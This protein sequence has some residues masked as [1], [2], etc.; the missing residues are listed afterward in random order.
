MNK[1]HFV[2]LALLITS[3]LCPAQSVHLHS[4]FALVLPKDSLLAQ[5]MVT[6]L[7]SFLILAHRG[8]VNNKFI[9]KDQMAETLVQQ[10]EVIDI[11]KNTKNKIDFFYQPYL[12]N[13]I[14]LESDKYLIQVSYLGI[15]DYVPMLRA[16]FDFIA[17]YI[18]G[19]FFFSS[20][21]IENTRDWKQEK[22]GSN[23]FFYRQHINEDNVM[24]FSS[25]ASE[26]DQKLKVPKMPTHYYCTYN[27][28]ELLKLIGVT[29]KSDYNGRS[30]LVFSSSDKDKKL[31]VL[32]N[33]N[34]SFDNFDPHDLWHDRL[35]LVISRRKVNKPID[36]ACAYLYG[37]SWGLTWDEIYALFKN[38]VASRSDADWA[39][40]K[41]TPY[42]FNDT[43]AAHLM[44]D[45][46]VNA[47]IVWKIEK[48]QGFDAVWTFLNCG[49]F[50]KGND[51]YY[52]AL[53]K[54]TSITKANYN[55]KVWE[56]IREYDEKSKI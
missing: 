7:D 40:Y 12:N 39:A 6:S 33:K 23:L 56:L 50:E 36:E 38:R 5:Q 55:Q 10:D 3:Y 29:Y 41:E 9:L 44:V 11:E 51:K 30:E 43:E 4:G 24:E 35:S 47:L 14:T 34:A 22:A 49:P 20:P 2:L 46:V 1:K 15:T 21:L 31:I 19:H 18:D 17:H 16:S 52:S 26:F 54:L 13:V 27:T 8:D 48:E 25:L 42:N 32:G 45:Y 53:A 28:A 37:G